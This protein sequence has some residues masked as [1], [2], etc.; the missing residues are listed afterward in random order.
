[1]LSSCVKI[2]SMKMRLSCAS[3]FPC[4]SPHTVVRL[5]LIEECG[6]TMHVGSGKFQGYCSYEQSCCGAFGGC[7]SV[8]LVGMALEQPFPTLAM[9]WIM[10]LV[11]LG[12]DGF[13]RY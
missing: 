5:I 1:M 4:E 7:R 8:H 12:A 9:H 13:P 2:N 10:V 3:G 11:K 6:H